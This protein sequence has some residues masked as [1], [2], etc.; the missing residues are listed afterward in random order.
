MYAVTDTTACNSDLMRSLLS[1]NTEIDSF[2]VLGDFLLE[3]FGVV[4]R[5]AGDGASQAA[6]V[7]VDLEPE[8]NILF[9]LAGCLHNKH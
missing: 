6:L 8:R 7:Q 4:E 1:F 3:M 2:V 5:G 9:K